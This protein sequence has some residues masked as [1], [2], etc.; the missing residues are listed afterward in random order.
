VCP[1]LD[2]SN[3]Y[4]F[5]ALKCGLEDDSSGEFYLYVVN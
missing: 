2:G 4:C 5:L 3:K 1:D